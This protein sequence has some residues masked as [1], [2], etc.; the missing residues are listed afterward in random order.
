MGQAARAA[1]KETDAKRLAMSNA[2]KSMEEEVTGGRKRICKKS[3]KS[4]KSRKVKEE[5][6]HVKIKEQK[7][8]NTGGDRY[9][10]D[11]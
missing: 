4:R 11:L 7:D 2:M 1:S 6:N 5:Q 3:R 8:V 10:S 9:A